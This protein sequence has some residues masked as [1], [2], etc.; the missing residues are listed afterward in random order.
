MNFKKNNG[1]RGRVEAT[2]ELTP[3]IDVIFLLLI[4][5]VMTTTPAIAAVEQLDIDLPDAAS[6]EPADPEEQVR[7][8]LHVRPDGEVFLHRDGEDEQHPVD[9][10]AHT[11][12]ELYDE[13]PNAAIWIR[14]DV[15][16]SHGAVVELLD[17]TRQ[18]GFERVRMAVRPEGG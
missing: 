2:L 12:G 8:T 1:R 4:F 16:A 14:G 7:V 9:D 6:A 10:V 3:L 13:H 5:F 11:M 18:V 17:V 15:E